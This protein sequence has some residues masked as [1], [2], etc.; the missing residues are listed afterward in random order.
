MVRR[1]RRERGGQGE[2][3]DN[4]HLYER[5]S[6]IESGEEPTLIDAAHRSLIRPRRAFTA[7]SAGGLQN[8]ALDTAGAITCWGDD[9]FGAVS[10]A[11]VGA[12][13]AVSGGKHYNCA[14]DTAGVI[15]CWG[16]EWWGEVS[17]AP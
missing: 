5:K 1:L 11:P 6:I 17:G 9:S 13:A 15:A 14:V 16:F 7:V 12:F 8:C 4:H 3:K 2:H 10:D